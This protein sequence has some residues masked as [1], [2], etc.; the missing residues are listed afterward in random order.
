MISEDGNDNLE[1]TLIDF[2]V[3]KRFREEETCR[4]MQLRT[5]T[6]NA[7]FTAPEIHNK[8]HYE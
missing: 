1:L 6:G 2:N 8:I 7:A 5:Y 4:K 3:S